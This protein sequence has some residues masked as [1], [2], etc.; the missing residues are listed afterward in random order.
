MNLWLC[1]TL[2]KAQGLS[3]TP[4]LNDRAKPGD[5]PVEKDDATLLLKKESISETEDN[6]IQTQISYLKFPLDI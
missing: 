4:L 5:Q 6:G 1:F 2:H 3:N